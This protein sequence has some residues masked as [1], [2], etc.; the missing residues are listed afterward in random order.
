MSDESSEMKGSLTALAI[1]SSI[2]FVTLVSLIAGVGA[3]AT[4][5]GIEQNRREL[6]RDLPPIEPTDPIKGTACVVLSE[7]DMMAGQTMAKMQP[8]FDRN[9]ETCLALYRP[10][11]ADYLV[12]FCEQKT[13]RP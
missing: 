4:K 13:A 9:L 12:C 8:Y 2:L 3:L 10:N 1:V 6:L 5:A 7:A 11:T